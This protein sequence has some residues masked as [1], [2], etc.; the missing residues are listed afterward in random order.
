MFPPPIL[1]SVHLTDPHLLSISLLLSY[2]S[3]FAH[4]SC[5]ALRTPR[6]L[7]ALL[8]SLFAL[9]T[10]C[11][12]LRNPFLP[13]FS[14]YH[15]PYFVRRAVQTE[16]ISHSSGAYDGSSTNPDTSTNQIEQEKDV[17]FKKSSANKETSEM[18]T[19]GE[20]GQQSTRRPSKQQQSKP[21]REDLGATEARKQGGR[22]GQKQ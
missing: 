8:T 6:S 18:A 19:K 1:D 3:L 12:A 7:L 4:F 10:L 20:M 14:P 5:F 11:L 21:D 17:N 16:D 22:G 15:A 13:T 2:S 9:R